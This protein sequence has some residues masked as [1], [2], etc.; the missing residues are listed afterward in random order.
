MISGGKEFVMLNLRNKLKENIR[1][2]KIAAGSIYE[3]DGVVPLKKA[4]PLGIQHV[5]A[6]FIG[7]LTPLMIVSAVAVNFDNSIMTVLIQNSMFVAGLI[8]L[9]QLYPIL[10]V[11]AK[12]PIVMGTSSGFIAVCKNIAMTGGYGAVIGASIVGG[13]F[14]MILGFF[15][16]PLRKL[17][18]PVVTSSVI[19]SIGLSLLP[20]GAKYFAGGEGSEL[21]GTWQSFL[22]GTIVLVTV[23]ILKQFTKGFL[24]VSSILIGIIVGYIA[25]VCL[26]MVDF[27]VITSAAWFSAPRI[28]PVKPVF[29]IG[30]ILSILIMYV[31][32][33]VETIGDTSGITVGGL[34]R[35]ATDQELA[36][37]VKADGF[38]SAFAALF[39][40]LPNT[41]F[42][43]N[44]GLVAV[45]KVVNR[46]VIATGAVFLIIMS[47]CPKLA[48]VFTAMPQSVL[49]GAAVIMFASIVLS[50]LQSLSKID[51]NGRNG[52]IIILALGV[53]MGMSQVEGIFDN[54]PASM[55]WLSTMFAQSGIIMTFLL[56]TIANLVLPK[57]KNN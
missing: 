33:A 30:S 8:T 44:V 7:N 24:N 43:Q 9:L 15:I 45:T 27:E 18:P 5:L 53:G 20:I 41:S 12:L 28:L 21:Y 37:S 3:L 38:G 56:A 47:F 54:L 11:G 19:L 55:H 50:G 36:G 4:I 29:E 49:G 14:E 25:A 26:G 2:G 6:M 35:E 46:F 32:T 52:M 34:G 48:A 23:V 17:F 10:K 57:D 1:A 13:I 42:S 40:C 31:A 22:V 39:G 51:L 16:K